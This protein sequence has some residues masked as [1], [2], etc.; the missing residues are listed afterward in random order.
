MDGER[1]SEQTKKTARQVLHAV[2]GD[3]DKEAEALEDRAGDDV[4][5]TAA[6]VAV[7]RA[8]GDRPDPDGSPG[9]SDLAAPDDAEKAANEG[10]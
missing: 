2:T 9:K 6:K 5:G 1:D 8:H 7:Q 4:D 10:T 3:R